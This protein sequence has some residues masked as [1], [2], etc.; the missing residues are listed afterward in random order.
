MKLKSIILASLV[1]SALLCTTGCSREE[2]AK[3]NTDPSTISK[4]EIPYL[5]TNAQLN[6]EPA[7]YLAWFYS[8]KYASWF[9]QAY[10]PSRGFTSD[11]IEMVANGGIG[12]KNTDIMKIRR[13]VEDVLSRMDATEAAKYQ[14]INAIL[15]S[16]LIYLAVLDTD[17]YGSMPYSEAGLAR[18]GGTL[19]PKYDTMEEMF[20][21]WIAELNDAIA[22]LTS[23]LSASGAI[24][25][26]DQD[27]IY[28][29]DMTKWAKFANSLKLKI[30]VRLLHIDKVRAL[31]LA[32]EVG[33]STAGVMDGEKDDFVYY[34]G[35][36]NYHFGDAVS[37]GACSKNVVDFMKKNYD[38]RLRF[39]YT[40]N[41]M[42]AEVVQAFFDAQAAGDGCVIPEYVMENI[43]YDVVNGKK[44]FKGWKG[45]GEPWVRYYGVPIAMDAASV[46]EWNG[47][48]NNYFNSNLWKVTLNGADKSYDMFSYFN[49]E[50]VRGQIDFTYPT[51]P[52]GV[53]KEDKDDVPWYGMYMSTAEINLYLAEMKMLG[54]TLPKSAKEYYEKAIALSPVEHDRLAKLNKIP[55]YD[56][57]HIYDTQF[58]KPIQLVDGEVA[59]MVS[60]PDYQ[61][62]GTDAE[63]LE[64]IY[65]QEYLHFMLQPI[66]QF[67]TVRRS[68][69]PKV[70]SQLIPWVN[71]L[72]KNDIPRRFEVNL[73]TNTDIMYD[74]K[75]KAYKE[76]G[77]TPGARDG[78]TLNSERVWYDKGAPDFGTGPKM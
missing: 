55:Y 65:I 38:P 58:E 45:Q 68:G 60:K 17:M 75:V 52:G 24:A 26:R 39:F 35:T 22:I 9:S 73:P 11:Y 7:G 30:A 44:V 69:V 56:E 61:F 71:L 78:K 67:V 20:G 50:T 34:K 31:K 59:T 46:P 70:N 36:Q 76:E 57:N 48:K 25:L 47:G 74:I 72:D 51:K 1:G 37:L 18:Y 63:K 6:F 13:E 2:F 42:N 14:H 43:N 64:K 16:M 19:T 23:N 66:D 40:K 62:T 54:A 41:S 8:G 12:D 77:F 10:T 28:G 5:L 49:Q 4:A 33:Q 32:A 27:I 21:I 3:I 29:G 15:R 53:V